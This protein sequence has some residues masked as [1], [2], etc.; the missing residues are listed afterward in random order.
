MKNEKKKFTPVRD[1]VALETTLKEEKITENGIVYTDNQVAD[2]YYV[3]STVYSVGPEVTEVKPGDEVMW[4]LGSNESQFY[5]DGE[6]VVDI[7]KFSDLL[8]VKCETE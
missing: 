6:F 4:K 1:L 7:V 3:W 5:K 8:V 2:N